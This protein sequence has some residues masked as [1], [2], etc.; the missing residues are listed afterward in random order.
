MNLSTKKKKNYERSF[1]LHKK[2][3]NFYDIVSCIYE[4][5][6]IFH[7]ISLNPTFGTKK[8]QQAAPESSCGEEFK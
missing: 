7:W 4:S 5:V 8:K 6:P 2:I 3:Y 1:N